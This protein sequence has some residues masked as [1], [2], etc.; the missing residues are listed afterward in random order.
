[1][2]HEDTNQRVCRTTESPIPRETEAMHI[3]PDEDVEMVDET[4]PTYTAEDEKT[5]D[6]RKPQPDRSDMMII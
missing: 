2:S 5:F 4:E 6:D 3:I 1:M